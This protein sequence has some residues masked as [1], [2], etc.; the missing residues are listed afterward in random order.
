[1]LYVLSIESGC[2]CCCCFVFVLFCFVLFFV[3]VAI[4]ACLFVCFSGDEMTF[5]L[6]TTLVSKNRPR[7]IRVT[8]VTNVKHRAYTFLQL[9]AS[10]QKKS[11]HSRS[12]CAMIRDIDNMGL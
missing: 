1:M 4:F 9:H 11:K 7:P 5:G 12:Q 10:Y 8:I 2:F 6:K 3:V